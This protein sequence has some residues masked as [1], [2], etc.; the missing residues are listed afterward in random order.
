[1]TAWQPHLP[2]CH[3][4]SVRSA[5]LG[6]HRPGP[7]THALTDPTAYLT[8]KP[9]ARRYP[10]AQRRTCTRGHLGRYRVGVAICASRG[11]PGQRRRRTSVGPTPT[12]RAPH[13]HLTVRAGPL[14][15]PAD[16]LTLCR[17]GLARANGRQTGRPG[18]KHTCGRD[19]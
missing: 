10:P 19:A 18:T 7:G 9:G 3:A 14:Q 17:A 5:S 2:V 4:A 16:A 15:L 1:M 11:L 12:V 8:L 13:A 6:T